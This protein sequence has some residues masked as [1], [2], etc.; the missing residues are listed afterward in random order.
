MATGTPRTPPSHLDLLEDGIVDQSIRL[1]TLLIRVLLLG[2]HTQYQPLRAWALRE[3]KGY[4]DDESFELLPRYRRI[5]VLFQGTLRNRV[6]RGTG[7]LS[8]LELPDNEKMRAYIGDVVR[9]GLMIPDG[10][11]KIE[12]LVAT[13]PADGAMTLAVRGGAELAVLM[14]VKRRERDGAW[15]ENVYWA[16]HVSD[17]QDLLDQVRTRLAEFVAELRLIMPRETTDPTTDQVEAAFQSINIRVGD[18]S[19]VTVHAPAAYAGAGTTASAV[20]SSPETTAASGPS[21]DE[22]GRRR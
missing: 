6:S 18:N 21:G 17:L 16:F 7:T 22:K 14:T 12:S 20:S 8:V 5:P 10:I 2:A 11:G 13:A 4:Q 9:N 1:T 15:V 19:P 3:L